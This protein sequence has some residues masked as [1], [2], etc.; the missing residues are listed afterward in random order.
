MRQVLPDEDIAD[1][2]AVD[3]E[4]AARSPVVA[5]HRTS[6]VPGRHEQ[7]TICKSMSLL[8]WVIWRSRDVARAAIIRSR[9][10]WAWSPSSGEK[11][12]PQQAIHHGERRPRIT[13]GGMGAGVL[14]TNDCLTMPPPCAFTRNR[15][16]I[17]R[18]RNA[19]RAHADAA[20]AKKRPTR[21]GGFAANIARLPERRCTE[22]RR[23]RA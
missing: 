13:E 8:S 11:G 1:G 3:C 20:A 18:N 10:Q 19:I 7:S 9:P 14:W 4:I 16:A 6:A 12:E 21:R 23:L 5:G 15:N 2:Q 22:R 17:S